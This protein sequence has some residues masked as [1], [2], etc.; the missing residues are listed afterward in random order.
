MIVIYLLTNLAYFRVLPADA[1]A[2]TDRVAG[3]MMRRVLGDR[4]AGAVSIVAMISI[5]AAL[6]GAILSGAR[7]PFAMARDGLFFRR[8]GFVHPGASNPSVSILALSAWAALLVLSGRYDQLYTYVI[9]ASAI[10]YGMA[11]ASVIVLRH[12]RPDMPRPYR[13]LG[14]PLVPVIFVLGIACLVVSTLLKSPRESLLGLG[15][16]ALGLALLFLLETK[17]VR[18]EAAAKSRSDG[19]SVPG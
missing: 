15:L 14:Y 12:K 5:F 2:S 1:V 8:V 18:A 13:T 10:L 11:T 3:E 19:G 17:P 4:G 7:V 9:F 6:N 16:I